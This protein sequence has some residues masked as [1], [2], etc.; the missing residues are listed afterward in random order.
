MRL[1]PNVLYTDGNR[2]AA[3][4]SGE[5]VGRV[6][7]LSGDLRHA[8]AR[9][10]PDGD[11]FIQVVADFLLWKPDPPLTIPQ[12]VNSAA[13]LCRLLRGEVAETLE[14]EEQARSRALSSQ[15]W[16]TTGGNF[17]SR[18]CPISRSLTRTRRPYV[19]AVLARVDG[20]AFEDR[21]LSEIAR[22]LGR[23]TR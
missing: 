15:A 14:R 7:R 21:P 18:A 3:F 6:A 20:I 23:S 4:R 12:L 5:L 22:Q 1:L 2:F 9:L 8:G 17:Y 10:A 13:K 16:P 19:R 11:D